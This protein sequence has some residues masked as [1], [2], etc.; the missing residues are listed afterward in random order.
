ME[1]NQNN[2]KA[3]ENKVEN[4]KIVKKAPAP[5]KVEA[6]KTDPAPKAET[7]KVETP[8][9]ENKNSEVKP[10]TNAKPKKEKKAKKNKGLKIFIVILLLLA[11]AGGVVYYLYSEDIISF[12]FDGE[13]TSSKASKDNTQTTSSDLLGQSTAT[14]DVTASPDATSNPDVT[15]SPDY[16][17]N[18]L[19][20]TEIN[21]IKKYMDKD[22]VCLLAGEFKEAKDANLYFALQ[23]G[24]ELKSEK[25][26][27]QEE[28]VYFAINT[29]ETNTMLQSGKTMEDYIEQVRD[30]MGDPI[31]KFSRENLD[32][33][34]K[35]NLDVT[36]K[37]VNLKFMTYV[38]K[39]DSY[40]MT[41]ASDAYVRKIT[42]LSGKKE[43]GIYTIK[44]KDEYNYTWTAKLKKDGSSY[45]ILSN[46]NDVS[47]KIAEINEI[48]GLNKLEGNYN[49]TLKYY[50]YYKGSD[51]YYVVIYNTSTGMEALE[52]IFYYDDNTCIANVTESDYLEQYYDY[53]YMGDKLYEMFVANK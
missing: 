10:T 46:V 52:E 44:Y 24:T 20:I 13:G 18:E 40:Y 21:E 42:I 41:R 4:K 26:T 17:N 7:P 15:A 53:S 48:K 30:I 43:D 45:I 37:D 1:Q 31:K 16:D 49:K 6:P 35:N 39:F 36:S 29:D 2:E 12:D 23:Y 27:K 11:I 34:L 38:E 32:K 9:V 8:K 14:P 50:A 3:K 19:S 28:L 33:Y 5:K 25:A 51:L 22:K 47:D